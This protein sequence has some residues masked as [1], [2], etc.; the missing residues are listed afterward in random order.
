MRIARLSRAAAIASLAIVAVACGGSTSSGTGGSKG[1][2]SIGV[3][4]PE[5]GEAASSGLRAPHGA[6]SSAHR[7]G[8]PATAVSRR[9]A[10]HTKPVNPPPPP[11]RMPRSTRVRHF[12]SGGTCCSAST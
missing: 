10:Q 9:G 5:S 2:I 1:T 4:L 12:V 8:T 7:A 11:W 3:D 6:E